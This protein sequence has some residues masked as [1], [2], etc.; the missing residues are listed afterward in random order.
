[1]VFFS[2]FPK[3]FGI[4][5]EFFW[6]ENYLGSINAVFERSSRILDP[7]VEGFVNFLAGLEALRTFK[8]KL[9][10]DL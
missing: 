2:E 6:H 5:E 4:F 10:L 7:V 3:V 8:R 9:I 1:M